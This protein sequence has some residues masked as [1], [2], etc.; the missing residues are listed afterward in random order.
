MRNIKKLD[1]REY[2]LRQS[3]IDKTAFRTLLEIHYSDMRRIG[4]N[5]SQLGALPLAEEPNGSGNLVTTGNY[6]VRV[7]EG[8]FLITGNSINKINLSIDGI[9]YIE[10]INFNDGT[11]FV[12]G[13]A[14][15]SRETLIHHQIYSRR[16]D[17]NVILH[18][19]DRLALKYAKTRST[20]RP[21]F[22]ANLEDAVDVV[23]ALGDGNYVSLPTHG[24]FVVGRDVNE[25]LQTA[26]FYHNYSFDRKP[27]SRIA[28][29]GIATSLAAGFALILSSIGV[30]Y[31]R[32]RDCDTINNFDDTFTVVCSTQRNCGYIKPWE[33]ES[34]KNIDG[35][36]ECTYWVG[37][38]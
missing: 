3:S 38:N 15:P 16:S 9:L 4:Y 18:T 34:A 29:V 8:G 14:K 23:D 12:S 17:V 2:I 35:H 1:P 24:Q 7:P 13:K 36:T 37:G 10:N 33:G 30:D 31:F 19:H 11:Y 28:K 26:E 22:F 21:I 5:L 6:S 27:T 32:F 25:A 20:H